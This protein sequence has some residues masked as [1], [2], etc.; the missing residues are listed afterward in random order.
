MATS[1]S[2]RRQRHS[3]VGTF[4][5][6]DGIATSFLMDF[7]I[8]GFVRFLDVLVLVFGVGSAYK[9]EGAQ[10]PTFISKYSVSPKRGAHFF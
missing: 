2:S 1:S 8:S 5:R 10:Q 6:R 4:Q 9:G 7:W 3:I